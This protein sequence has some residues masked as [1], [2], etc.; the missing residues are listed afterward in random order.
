MPIRTWRMLARPIISQAIE[1]GRS[2]GLAGK[3][4]RK[5]IHARYPWG[6]RAMHPYK[7]WLSEVNVQLGQKPA[8]RGARPADLPGQG[9]LF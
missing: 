7:V 3:P 6:E 5:Y 4:L 9:R 8:P 1:E 2:L